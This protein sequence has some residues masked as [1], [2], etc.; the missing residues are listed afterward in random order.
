VGF[1]QSDQRARD[2]LDQVSEVYAG[3]ETMSMT[4]AYQLDN[5]NEGISQ[6]EEGTILVANDKY[7]LSILGIQQLFDG[8]SIYTID[9]MNEEVI[10]Q[11][12]SSL[13]NPLNPLDIFDFHK[14]GYLL[15]WDIAQ[16]VSGRDIRYVKLIPTE[17]KSQSKYLLLGIDTASNHLYK[18]IDLGI[19]G[20]DTT[21]TVQEFVPN[22]PIE[23]E[24]FVF[25]EDKYANYYIDRF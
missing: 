18:I 9:D 8:T 3:Y 1:S 13:D 5:A 20:T 23:P 7:K 11:D 17:P 4:F 14:E 25:D 24:T 2:L 16:R 22:A 6:K 19:N 12:E 15:Q 21:F 10:V